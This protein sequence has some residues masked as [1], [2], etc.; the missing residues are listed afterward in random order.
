ME[1]ESYDTYRPKHA[2]H[3]N[4]R[5]DSIVRKQNVQYDSLA[6]QSFSNT[7]TPMN[8]IIQDQDMLITDSLKLS[9]RFQLLAETDFT[10]DVKFRG[11]AY[12]LIR[13]LQIYYGGQAFVN[14]TEHGAQIVQNNRTIKLSQTEYAQSS[15]TC[16]EDVDLNVDGDID[17]ECD[18]NVYGLIKRFLPTGDLAKI[19]IKIQF[20]ND[21]AKV[22]YSPDGAD[23]K[24]T[25]FQINDC[26]ITADTLTY[27]ANVYERVMNA[28]RSSQGVEIPS[29]SYQATTQNFVQGMTTHNL[30]ATATYTN[31]ISAWVLPVPQ[32]IVAD[33][34]TGVSTS[35]TISKVSY[36]NKDYPREFIMKLGNSGQSVNQNGTQGCTKKMNHYNGVLK[37]ALYTHKHDNVGW[38]LSNLYKS[39]DYQAAAGCWLKGLD[40]HENILN[41]GVNTYP[42]NGLVKIQFKTASD[43]APAAA[44]DKKAA[45]VIF[46][47]TSVLKVAQGQI[48][49]VE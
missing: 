26:H 46:E 42:A 43:Q 30:S 45:L 4:S 34:T 11:S 36:R 9:G 19:E 8:T 14:I 1:T 25:G 38:K 7:K 2:S 29:H 37:T 48:M 15:L 24:V 20:E 49:L 17:F 22:F 31:L 33:A 16:L 5:I 18:L 32:D 39:N 41:S 23:G 12:S 28:F 6:G 3:K 44:A 40:N 10:G 35:D 47:Y 21:L 13:S 27:D